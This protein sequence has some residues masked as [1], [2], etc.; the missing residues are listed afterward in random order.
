MGMMGNT[1]A[2]HEEK[3]E[4]QPLMAVCVCVYLYN[5][6]PFND[7]PAV[8]HRWTMQRVVSAARHDVRPLRIGQVPEPGYHDNNKTILL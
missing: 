1:E 5:F 8:E 2:T 3:L 7:L 4:E 6:S